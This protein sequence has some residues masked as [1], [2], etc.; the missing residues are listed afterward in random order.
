MI[1]VTFTSG[2][3][4]ETDVGD[5]DN[6]IVSQH[7]LMSYFLFLTNLAV[8]FSVTRSEINVELG[9]VSFSRIGV[10]SELE[11]KVSYVAVKIP[12]GNSPSVLEGL[13]VFA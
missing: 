10:E 1:Q 9:N 6:Q 3:D 12:F 13:F 5:A 11:Q 2:D 4:R 8:M 7:F